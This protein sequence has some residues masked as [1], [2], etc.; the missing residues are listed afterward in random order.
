LRA[1]IGD[2]PVRVGLLTTNL[3]EE[4][5]MTDEMMQLRALVEKNPDADILR[6]MIG[7]AAQRLMETQRMPLS[8][9]P[10]RP[11]QMSR[12]IRPKTMAWRVST[13]SQAKTAE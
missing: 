12:Y 6:E 11:S 1:V 8:R 3:T 4:P 9:P 13:E 5:P 7:F 10:S 2:F